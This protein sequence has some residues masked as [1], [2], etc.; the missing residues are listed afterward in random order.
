MRTARAA[1]RSA[2]SAAAPSALG[3][4][5]SSALGAWPS[6][7]RGPLN[8][9]TARCAGRQVWHVY[10]MASSWVRILFSGVPRRGARGDELSG[11]PCSVVPGVPRRRALGGLVILGAV[12]LAAAG[13]RRAAPAPE[14]GRLVSLTPSATEVIDAL[15]LTPRLVGV[16][17]YS[18]DPAAVKALPKVGSFLAPNLEAIVALR[19]QY[20]VADDVHADTAAAL[21]EAGVTTLVYPMHSLADLQTALTAM[22]AQLGRAERAAQ[23]LHEIEEAITAAQRAKLTPAPRVLVVIDREAGGVGNLVCAATGSW[24][25]QLLAIVGADNVMAASGVRYPKVSVEEVIKA[26]PAIIL[27]LSFAG[28]AEAAWR[29][30]DVAATRDHRVIGRTDSFLLRPSP[31]V[32]AALAVLRELLKPR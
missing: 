28:D 22:G 25:D 24:I 3:A 11:A 4:W 31:R 20:V 10:A 2:P 9:V 6:P 23:V 16:D 14:G 5:R 12:L 19:P 26:N 1:E 13:C 8:R 30:V 32:P 27:D 21:R 15:G 18:E 29:S 7:A 17:Q